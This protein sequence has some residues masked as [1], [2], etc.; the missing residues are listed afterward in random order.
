[1]AITKVD[2]NLTPLNLADTEINSL[3]EINRRNK[4][5]GQRWKSKA[6]HG[7]FYT[8]MNNEHVVDQNISH[9]W[10]QNAGIFPETEGCMIRVQDQAIPTRN[11]RK[12][13][14]KG[15]G[16]EDGRRRCGAKGETIQH[17]LNGCPELV[18]RE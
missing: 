8:E 9:K 3:E 11:D 6:V 13:V 14:L 15:T 18:A 5:K 7:K 17:I 2:M 16:V 1:M 12:L 10:L 4:I